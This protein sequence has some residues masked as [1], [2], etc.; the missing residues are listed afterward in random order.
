MAH[1]NPPRTTAVPFE[2]L[3]LDPNGPPGNAWG[4]FGPNDQLG[5]LNLLTP[6]VVT[7]AAKEIR[8]GVR[9]SLDWPLDK[10][11]APSFGRQRLS[12]HIV[13]K[14]T[15]DSHDRAVNDD[16]V[17][18]NTQGSSQW[19]GF[20]HYGHLDSCQFYGG[21]TLNDIHSSKTQIGIDAIA[22]AGGIVGRGVLIDFVA[23]A[24]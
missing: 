3:T 10:P 22:A 15:A 2:K 4:R 24:D 5:M 18:F 16:I 17:T 21:V 1:P 9:V 11:Y 12:H 19:D 8:T 23:W 14:R 6:E 20:R 13:Q 7:E